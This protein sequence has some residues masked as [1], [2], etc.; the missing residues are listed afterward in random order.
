MVLSRHALPNGRLHQPRQ[1][2]EHVDGGIDLGKQKEGLA[3]G[4]VQLSLLPLLVS[5][6]TPRSQETAPH[7]S[8]REVGWSC[9]ALLY[10]PQILELGYA[11]VYMCAPRQEVGGGT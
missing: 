5:P 6:P 8:H 2:R 10:R 3:E 1:G 4:S 9:P 7:S 11:G